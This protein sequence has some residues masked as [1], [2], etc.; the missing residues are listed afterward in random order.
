MSHSKDDL[1]N[2]IAVDEKAKRN[3][4][5]VSKAEAKTGAADQAQHAQ[6]APH[7]DQGHRASKAVDQ[8]DQ[9][10]NDHSPQLGHGQSPKQQKQQSQGRSDLGKSGAD[11]SQPKFQPKSDAVQPGEKSGITGT[12]MHK[13]QS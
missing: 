5:D 6:G 12:D 1:Q 10:Q 7:Q 11:K 8:K 3:Q 9:S 4:S 13:Q 2:H